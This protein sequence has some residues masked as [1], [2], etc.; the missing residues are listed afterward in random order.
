[1][2]ERTLVCILVDR[3]PRTPQARR[4]GFCRASY[5]NR[6]LAVDAENSNCFDAIAHVSPGPDI[7]PLKTAEACASITR[8][9][10]E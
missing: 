6:Q 10:L 7:V 1:M 4:F 9:A 8:C 5:M 2:Q 3:Q